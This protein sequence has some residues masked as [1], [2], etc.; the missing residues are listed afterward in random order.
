MATAIKHPVPDRVK[1]SFIF[2]DIWTL[3]QPWASECQDVKNCKWWL[4]AVWH[5][6]FYS[7]TVY[8]YGNSG[9]QRIKLS[10]NR[11]ISLCHYHIVSYSKEAYSLCMMSW[12]WYKKIIYMN[13][14]SVCRRDVPLR[15]SMQSTMLCYVGRVMSRQIAT[16]SCLMLSSSPRSLSLSAITV[17]C[18]CNW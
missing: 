9:R 5:W 1:P 10:R 8:P 2:F 16:H 4:N 11:V 14:F 3:W 13:C 17:H 18:C 15:E 7:C 6:M 12:R